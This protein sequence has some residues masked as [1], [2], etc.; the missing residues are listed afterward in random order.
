MKNEAKTGLD[1]L[2]LITFS[3]SNSI[4]IL[5]LFKLFLLRNV[6]RSTLVVALRRLAVF[7]CAL[8]GKLRRE[9]DK[10]KAREVNPKSARDQRNV[11]SRRF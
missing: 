10:K 1:D 7:V 9:E 11:K 2:F 6:S 4:S 5:G 3:T 8:H